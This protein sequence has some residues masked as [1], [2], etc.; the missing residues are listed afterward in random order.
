MASNF[1][2]RYRLEHGVTAFLEAMSLDKSRHEAYF[3]L[4]YLYALVQDANHALYFLD[5]AYK[6]SGDPAVAQLQQQVRIQLGL[7]TQVSA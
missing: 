7:K 4:G 1:E 6:I 5:V 2:E 3:G